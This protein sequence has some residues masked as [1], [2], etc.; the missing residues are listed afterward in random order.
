MFR[1]NAA[2]LAGAAVRVHVAFS[3]TSAA[4][5]LTPHCTEEH[6]NSEDESTEGAPGLSQQ[7]CENQGQNL[8]VRSSEISNGK[9]QEDDVV[10]LESTIAV[11]ILVERAMHLSLKGKTPTRPFFV[12]V[13]AVFICFN[14][15]FPA[16]VF[17]LFVSWGLLMTA[18]VR[19]NLQTEKQHLFLRLI[20]T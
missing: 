14:S 5:T 3:S 12:L 16:C 8:D 7:V 18:P 19:S 15:C 6:S 13:V 9:P 17:V 4:P 10:F 2:D 11:S 20:P 1:C